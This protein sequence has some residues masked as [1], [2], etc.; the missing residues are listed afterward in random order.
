MDVAKSRWSVNYDGKKPGNWIVGSI[1]LLSS[2]VVHLTYMIVCAGTA[3]AD[4]K[5]K[6]KVKEK[7]KKKK[8]RRKNKQIQNNINQLSTHQVNTQQTHIYRW[9]TQVGSTLDGV[10]EMGIV[11]FGVSVTD[12][13]VESGMSI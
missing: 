6:K 1:E 13:E 7:E 8:K 4:V 5:F 2:L 9:L 3:A 12:T 11:G 10:S